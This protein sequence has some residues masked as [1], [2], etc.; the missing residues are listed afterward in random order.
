MSPQY[1][2][3]MAAPEHART[4]FSPAA[5]DQFAGHLASPRFLLSQPLGVAVAQLLTTVIV[6]TFVGSGFSHRSPD[7]IRW[8]AFCSDQF[9]PFRSSAPDADVRLPCGSER[10]Q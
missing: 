6:S 8:L 3:I 5:I 4:G 10:V 2:C 7:L 1:Q 9:S